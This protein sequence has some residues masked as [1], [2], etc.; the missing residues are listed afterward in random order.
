MRTSLHA[1]QR[2]RKSPTVETQRP[3][4]SRK[5][6]PSLYDYCLD[7]RASPNST[8]AKNHGNEPS[9]GA[10]IDQQIKEEEEEILK[11]KG[12]FGPKKG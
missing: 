11:K 8:Q 1:S 5:M 6:L 3:R 12:S 7:I 9:K 2:E 10:K 4:S